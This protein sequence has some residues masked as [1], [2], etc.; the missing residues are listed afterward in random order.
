MASQTSGRTNAE[1]KR[2]RCCSHRSDSRRTTPPRQ[3]AYCA[4]DNPERPA[5]TAGSPASR[6]WRDLPRR[7]LPTAQV[8]ILHQFSAVLLSPFEDE[9]ERPPG[10]ASF[11]DL[12]CTNVNSRLV[13]RIERVKVWGRVFLPKYLD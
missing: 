9:C 11:N 5:S 7:L 6:K 2:P 10:Q 1:T 3:I 13:L 4:A 12:Q 8:P